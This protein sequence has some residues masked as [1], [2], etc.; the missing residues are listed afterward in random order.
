M[1]PIVVTHVSTYDTRGGAG[2][3][4]TR[5]HLAL[6]KAGAKSSQ[7]VRFKAGTDPHTYVADALEME[8]ADDSIIAQVIQSEYIDKRRTPVSNT[9]FSL[10]YPGID[11]TSHPI[12]AHSDI[13]NLHWVNSFLSIESIGA[14]L[15]K[16]IPVVWTLHD[17]HAFTG[18]CHYSA[19]CQRFTE[20]CSGCPQLVSDSRGLISAR[21]R[22]RIDLFSGARRPLIVTPSEWM[23]RCVLKSAVFRNAEVVT[24]ANSVPLDKFTPG[25]RQDARRALGVNEAA[26]CILFGA[27]NHSENRKG[28]AVLMAALRTGLMDSKVEQKLRQITILC[29]GEP[30]EE[31]MQSGLHIF[32]LGKIDDEARLRLAYVAADLFV[33]PSLEDNL[34]NTLLESLACGTPVLAF[35]VGGIPEAVQHGETGWLVPEGNT[36]E[37]GHALVHLLGDPERLQVW[38]MAARVA[39][40]KFFSP[41]VQAQKYLDIYGNFVRSKNAE[42]SPKSN[43]NKL[44]AKPSPYYMNR[45]PAFESCFRSIA[46]EAI[47]PVYLALAREHEITE[48]DRAHRVQQ[49]EELAEMLR[50]SEADRAARGEQIALLSAWLSESESDRSARGSQIETLS[51]WL[52]ESEADRAA[53][54]EQISNFA[55]QLQERDAG[56]ANLYEQRDALTADLLVL[57]D[58]LPLRWLAKLSKWSEFEKLKDQLGRRDE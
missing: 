8:A 48:I 53:R 2:I 17:Q 27:E 35:S 42:Y 41:S 55:V 18:G 49:I 33:L 15:A 44:Q 58:R 31:L 26:Q 14:V 25:S 36:D 13:V 57:L 54:G 16:G 9:L 39:A 45:T 29:F 51:A 28:F 37:F 40:E 6:R 56:L 50:E 20:G 21:L 7:L 12:L 38:S 3:A 30:A 46:S 32:S 52:K 19:G 11:P 47:A 43:D 4:A 24:V 34:P 23:R 10:G 5:L 22:D 1:K